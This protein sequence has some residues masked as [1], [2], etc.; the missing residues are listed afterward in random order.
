MA[1]WASWLGKKNT[2]FQCWDRKKVFAVSCFSFFSRLLC[3]TVRWFTCSVNCEF[4]FLSFIIFFFTLL[5]WNLVETQS[6]GAI[7]LPPIPIQTENLIKQMLITHLEMSFV[8][9]REGMWHQ[10]DSIHPHWPFLSSH[11]A[12][13]SLF[14]WNT[15]KMS[16]DFL[17]WAA[18]FHLFSLD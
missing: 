14:N 10:F 2:K 5:R 18:R 7:C 9:N 4:F 11:C 6:T 13:S 16:Q 15:I 12:T 3:A 8:N 17:Q 1:R